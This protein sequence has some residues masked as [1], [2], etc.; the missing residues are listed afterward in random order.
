MYELRPATVDDIDDIAAFTADTFSW[1]D[2]VADALPTWLAR[3]DGLVL[4]AT[5]G[6]VAVA[7]SRTL[8]LSEHEAWLHGARVHPAHRRQ[9][10]GRMLNEA[11]C[12]WAR[13][14]GAL[15]AR[16]LVEEWNEA[17]KAQV[18]A[19]GYR[20]GSPWMS[21]TLELGSEVLPQ[22]NGGRRVPGEERLTPGRA[23]E[24]D[25]AWM[26]WAASDLA[27]TGRELF[28][29]GW[30]FRRM[31][32]IDLSQSATRRELWHCPSGWAMATSSDNGELTV[33]WVS[34]TDLDVARLIRALIDLADGTRAEKIR[35]MA[36]R[37]EWMERALERAGFAIAPNSVYGRNLE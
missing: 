29:V 5:I 18:E 24:A 22:T 30:H 11:G 4:A 23:A 20:R 9:G 14:Q 33:Q 28:P 15:V 31:R 25:V 27:R 10:L 16:L 36:P 26:S 19:I 2:Y 3:Q 35:V 21:A 7:V 34:T 12:A 17:A 1:G 13:T 8:M 37:L 6:D 32:P